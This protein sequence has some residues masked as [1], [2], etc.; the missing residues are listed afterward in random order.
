[1]NFEDSY[2]MKMNNV[3]AVLFEYIIFSVQSATMLFREE[4]ESA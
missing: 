3:S 4:R 2:L 1:M